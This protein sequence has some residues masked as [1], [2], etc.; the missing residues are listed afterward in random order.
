MLGWVE[1][2][3]MRRF[4]VKPGMREHGWNEGNKTEMREIPGQARN[5][6]DKPGMRGTR[7][8]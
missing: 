8:E 1:Y 4:R 3:D 6:V 2:G 7:L 5:E